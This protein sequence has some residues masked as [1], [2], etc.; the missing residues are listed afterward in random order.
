MFMK[1]KTILL[2]TLIL[3][4]GIPLFI[5]NGIVHADYY[6]SQN[7]RISDSGTNRFFWTPNLN[8]SNYTGNDTG[9]TPYKVVLTDGSGKTATGYLGAQGAGETLGSETLANPGVETGLDEWTAEGYSQWFWNCDFW[10]HSGSYS[11]WAYRDLSNPSDWVRTG[12]INMI[13][14]AHN[15]YKMVFYASG[16]IYIRRSA[17]SQSGL[18]DGT[19]ITSYSYR[20]ETSTGYWSAYAEAWEEYNMAHGNAAVDD[21]SVKQV[22]DGPANYSLHVF[23]TKGGTTRGWTVDSGFDYTATTYTVNI[24][25]ADTCTYS[26]GN[27]NVNCYDNCTISAN[28]NLGNNNLIFT[29]SGTFT[30][31]ADIINFNQIAISNGCMMAIANGKKFG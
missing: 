5:F 8:L 25:L 12:R 26:S 22:T 16:T 15:L 14:S 3:F 2:A 9:S 20:T 23:T 6:G 10:C 11:S 4:A 19:L 28:V 18:T 21:F 30:V 31:N 13:L 17:S 24:T 7:C 27:W 29:G 1:Q